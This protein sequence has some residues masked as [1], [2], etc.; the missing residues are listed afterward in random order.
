MDTVSVIAY[1]AQDDD[2]VAAIG[3]L[4]YLVKLSL[5][6]PFVAVPLNG[7]DESTDG[8]VSAF[9]IDATSMTE[10]GLN[11]LLANKGALDVLRYVAVTTFTEKGDELGG[12]SAN[13]AELSDR[14]RG[15]TMNK[16]PLVEGRLLVPLTTD[17][18]TTDEFFGGGSVVNLIALP[19]DEIEIDSIPLYADAFTERQRAAHVALEVA[20]VAGIWAGMEGS[21]LD[22][23]SSDSAGTP[24]VR[25]SFVSSAARVILDTSPELGEALDVTK[26]LPVPS[27]YLSLPPY[28][29]VE[30]RAAKEIYPRELR[31]LPPRLDVGDRLGSRLDLLTLLRELGRLP[32][33]AWRSV[34]RDL[35]ESGQE[36]LRTI[37]NQAGFDD[38]EIVGDAQTGQLLTEA[39]INAIILS[40]E[41]EAKKPRPNPIPGEYWRSLIGKLMGVLDGGPDGDQARA[42][43]SSEAQVLIDQV[44]ITVPSRDVKKVAKAVSA[45]AEIP[46][47]PTSDATT[48]TKSSTDADDGPEAPKDEASAET[49]VASVSETKQSRPKRTPPSYRTVLTEI[50]RQFRDTQSVA[51]GD[52]DNTAEDLKKTGRALAEWQQTDILGLIPWV[53]ALAAFLAGFGLIALTPFRTVVDGLIDGTLRSALFATGSALVIILAGV[54]LLGRSGPKW[55]RNATIAAVFVGLLVGVA[56]AFS[57]QLLA[58]ADDTIGRWLAGLTAAMAVAGVIKARKEGHSATARLLQRTAI[59]FFAL[60]LIIGGARED[61]LVSELSPDTMHRLAIALVVAALLMAVMSAIIVAIARV[62]QEN[63][64]ASAALRLEAGRHRLVVATDASRRLESA[65]RQWAWTGSSLNYVIQYP[66]GQSSTTTRPESDVDAFGLLRFQIV[67]LELGEEGRSALL[68][69]RLRSSTTAGWLLR[70]YDLAVE[71]FT[72][73][74]SRLQGLPPGSADDFN[75]DDDEEPLTADTS[76]AIRDRS[77]RVAFARWLNTGE[78]DETLASPVLSDDMVDVYRTVLVHDD[79]Y[80]LIMLSGPENGHLGSMVDLFHGIVPEKPRLLDP[81]LVARLFAGSGDGQQMVSTVWWPSEL[82]TVPLADVGHLQWQQSVPFT[83]DGITERLVLQAVRFDRSQS[84]PFHELAGEMDRT[85]TPGVLDEDSM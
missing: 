57:D 12:I 49:K 77:P 36:N 62:Q 47:E 70:Q 30:E 80:R 68:A 29:G 44:R 10:H 45:P 27:R 39:D 22:T 63:A 14:I 41:H 66:F 59:T 23:W 40:A 2:V 35:Y 69:G 76:S 9:S 16:V 78:A 54:A 58:E 64:I 75:P 81:A 28:P 72:L 17:R 18:L 84:F 6:H 38:I 25:A 19:E 52:I 13:A 60:V 48:T 51:H 37:L 61:S 24:A 74:E 71:T 43:L 5:C 15:L 65:I 67:E 4:G 85:T 42:A 31:Y 50:G 21:P 3:I 73:R 34:Q 1:S 11:E 26:Y 82:T 7:V 79:N 55:H 46:A 83:R 8:R 20:T 53:L 33:Y 56:S 32:S